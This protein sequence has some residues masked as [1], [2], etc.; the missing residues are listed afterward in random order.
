[1][2]S[3]FLEALYS[4]KKI[5]GS[6]NSERNVLVKDV[7]AKDGTSVSTKFSWW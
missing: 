3:A 7:K 6:L 2:W 1:M 4:L 5:I